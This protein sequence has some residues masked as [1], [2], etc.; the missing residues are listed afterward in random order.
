[1]KRLNTLASAAVIALAA[2]LGTVPAQA[3]DPGWRIVASGLDN[4][5]HL[6]FD[7]GTLYVAEAG[8]GGSGPCMDG[9]EGET[10]FGTTGAITQIVRGHQSRVLSG[11]PSL[12][13]T[14]GSSAIGATDVQVR[15]HRYTVTI[16]LG[17][18]P[19]VRTTLPGVGRKLLGTMVTG[20]FA[21]RSHGHGHRHAKW[22]MRHGGGPR[23]LADLAGYEQRVDPDGV[24]PDSNPGGFASAG[25]GFVVA[26]AGANALLRVSKHGAISTLGVLDSPGTAKAPFP[27]FED[28]P[29]QAVPT[30]IVAGPHGSWYVSELTGF[31]FQPGAARIHRFSA[32]GKHTVYATGL[33]N[34]TDLAWYKGSLYAVQLADEG[35]LSSDNPSGSLVRVRPGHAAKTVVDNLQAPYGVAFRSNTAYVTTCAVCPGGGSVIA[36]RMH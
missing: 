31:P 32:T 26:D 18:N 2:G 11:L 1:M 22:R 28:V 17:A 24:G 16:G 6:S 29:M 14:D 3:A 10:C 13:G 8:V 4:P 27:P 5:R 19:A 15:G 30:S 36:A 9:P 7:G 12:G 21:H 23:V 34:V 35:L 25:S 33:T 20:K